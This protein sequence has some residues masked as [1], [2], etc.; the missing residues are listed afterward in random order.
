MSKSVEAFE[1]KYG[2]RENPTVLSTRE[3]DLCW[4]AWQTC[5]SALSIQQEADA[6][7]AARY[8]WLC[9]PKVKI[10]EGD[11]Y[12]VFIGEGIDTAIDTA[13]ATPTDSE[14]AAYQAEAAERFNQATGLNQGIAGE[15]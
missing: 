11:P 5:E 10:N 2:K 6:K 9:D 3:W 4:A 13:M 12:I 1:Y 7:D 8:R 15:K 14:E